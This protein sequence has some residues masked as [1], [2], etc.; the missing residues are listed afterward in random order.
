MMKGEI[1]EKPKGG[2][3]GQDKVERERKS[4]GYRCY[5]EKPFSGKERMRDVNSAK[6]MEKRELRLEEK[7]VFLM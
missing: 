2:N 1:S 5:Y 3:M 6:L 7:S 4:Y